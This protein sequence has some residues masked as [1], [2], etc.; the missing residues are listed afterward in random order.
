MTTT[1]D[2][3]TAAFARR[4]AALLSVQRSQTKASIRSLARRSNGMVTTKI[5]HAIEAGTHPLDGDLVSVVAALYGADLEAILPDRMIVSVSPEGTVAAGPVAQ[6]FDPADE[7]AVLVAYLRLVR[8]LRGEHRAESLVLRRDDVD[9][10][11]DY[12]HQ[13][14]TVVLE[15]LLSLMGSTRAQR[16]AVMALFATGAMVVGLSSGAAAFSGD[17]G[18]SAAVGAPAP[19]GAVLIV[20]VPVTSS[21]VVDID[22]IAADI[23][24][25]AADIAGI[26]TD[27]TNDT[28]T[29]GDATDDVVS[30]GGALVPPLAATPA[31]DAATG[32]AGAPATLSDPAPAPAPGTPRPTTNPAPT[33]QAPTDQGADVAS[34]DQAV[35]LPDAEP[36]SATSAPEPT[37][38]EPLPI[39]LATGNVLPELSP[40][41]GVSEAPV[42]VDAPVDPPAEV[43]TGG[44]VLPPGAPPIVAP[45]PPPPPVSLGGDQVAEQVP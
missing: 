44:V 42:P 8:S 9:V 14:G 4:L 31:G 45:T 12:L 13:P 24:G 40:D 36:A 38:V 3:T 26:A 1:I 28:T 23:A 41:L 25:I 21:G 2:I 30:V 32:V 33:G 37:S 19:T 5:L 15:R 11:A 16:S 35:P 6:K 7:N 10:L 27:T 20:D 17:T 29:D 22:D 39:P 34:G 18:S 43:N